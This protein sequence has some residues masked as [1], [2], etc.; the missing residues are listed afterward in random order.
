MQTLV[1]ILTI[2]FASHGITCE[3]RQQQDKMRILFLR[4]V[5]SVIAY[6]I[7]AFWSAKKE[8]DT[9]DII[10]TSLIEIYSEKLYSLDSISKGGLSCKVALLVTRMGVKDTLYSDQFLRNWKIR[11]RIVVDKSGYFKSIFYPLLSARI[12]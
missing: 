5:E 12:Q 3:G 8:H 10:S 1:L 11:D 9:I 7:E 2:L 6:D 4:D